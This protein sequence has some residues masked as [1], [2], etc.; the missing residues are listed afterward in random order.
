V[1]KEH[2]DYKNVVKLLKQ[3]NLDT[4]KGG[5]SEFVFNILKT[6]VG[7]EKTEGVLHKLRLA[8]FCDYMIKFHLQPKLIKLPPEKLARFTGMDTQLINYFLDTFTE[9]RANQAD[10]LQYCRTNILELKLTYHI[11]VIALMLYD[12]KFNLNPLARSLKLENKKL[13]HY[14]REIGCWVDEKKH[15]DDIITVTLKAPLTIKID[16]VIK[17]K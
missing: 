1:L 5:Y 12:Y 7:K 8:V 10:Q 13:I 9:I 4:L 16:R 14:C 3:D 11:L 6:L 2:I 15:K 17:H